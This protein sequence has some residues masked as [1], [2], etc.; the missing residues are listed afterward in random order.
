MAAMEANISRHCF[1]HSIGTITALTKLS[2][3]VSRIQ[4]RFY[5]SIIQTTN[6][7]K[8]QAQDKV[9]QRLTPGEG[10][11]R[12]L[13]AD[14]GRQGGPKQKENKIDVMDHRL[15]LWIRVKS[16]WFRKVCLDERSRL[17]IGV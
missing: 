15:R 14:W 17:W 5:Q 11:L 3:N 4:Q 1:N 6:C 12:D 8:L 16:D 10:S 9:T 13:P 2:H 7:N